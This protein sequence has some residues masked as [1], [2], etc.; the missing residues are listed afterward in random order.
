MVTTARARGNAPNIV[1]LS[2]SVPATVDIK[3]RS[4]NTSIVR[5]PIAGPLHIV[6]DGIDGNET[7]VHTEHVLAFTAEHYD[8]WTREL[9][10]PRDAWPWCWWGEN[11]TVTGIAEEELRIG[12]ILRAGTA[13]FRVTSPRIPC[14]KVAWRIGQPD[15][16]LPRL[17]ESGRV[18]FHLEVMKPGTV[19]LGDRL[20]VVSSSPDAIT[21]ADLS[22]LLLSQSIED[23]P[24]L[25]K[26]LANPALG[27]KA[28]GSVRHRITFIEDRDRLRIGRWRGWRPFVVK[29][30]A[31]EGEGVRS[32]YFEPED[33]EPLAPPAAGQFLTVKTAC[34]GEPDIVRPWTIS[35]VDL[36]ER[37]YRVSIKAIEGGAGS[38]RMHCV[39]RTGDT[40]WARPPAGQF[41]L[42]RS[43]YRRIVLV[44]AGIGVTPLLAMLRAYL[45]LEKAP[46][47]IWIQ[48]VKNSR[49][50][51][52]KREVADLL[53]QVPGAR[54][55]IHYTQPLPEDRA[56]ID[57]DIAGRL[58]SQDLIPI[59]ST[60]YLLN[61]FGREL[62]FPGQESEAYICGPADFQDMVRRTMVQAGVKPALIRSEAFV[63]A[64][65]PGGDSLPTVER[66]TVTFTRSGVTADWYADDGQT[67]LDLAEAVGLS[68]PYAC[69]SGLCQS[70]QCPLKEGSVQYDPSPPE[71]PEQGTVLICCARPASACLQIDL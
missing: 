18:G 22:R 25:R 21:L 43:G 37:H 66:A 2:T 30:I 33:D 63:S 14:F 62:P 50:H 68:P 39:L 28:A 19:S 61:P 44:S 52:F 16:I 6:S 47:L 41:V 48:V 29:R 59:F 54:R 60:H 23:V 13:E 38:Q 11:M 15:S 57:Y 7:A 20:D 4:I 64:T 3:G 32:F 9:D 26:T 42:D 46:P 1:A 45:E 53:A 24:L 56:G 8:Y 65:T 69:R 17:M 31:D 10:V 71:T 67:L 34:A 12:D 35:G 70:C 49:H 40:V 36:A 51:P 27:S 5:Q 58:R 55:I